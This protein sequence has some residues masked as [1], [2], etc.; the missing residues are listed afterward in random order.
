MRTI[1]ISTILLLSITAFADTNVEST[2]EGAK[3]Y[4]DFQYI[5][6]NKNINDE[7]MTYCRWAEASAKETLSRAGARLM[8]NSSDADILFRFQ[9]VI[10]HYGYDNKCSCN[11]ADT[12][13]SVTIIRSKVTNEEGKYLTV[14][15]SKKYGSSISKI[16][17]ISLQD[18]MYSLLKDP[19][20]IDSIKK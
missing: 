18:A 4:V 1:L 14:F 9:D 13:V 11:A 16:I 2:W 6:T 8:L 15:G 20:A 17:K 19:L 10:V 3:T 12:S 7:D 5:F